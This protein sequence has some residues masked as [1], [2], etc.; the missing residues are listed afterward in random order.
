MNYLMRSMLSG[1]DRGRALMVRMIDNTES[2][3]EDAVRAGAI[4]PSRD[5]KARAGV[6]RHERRR[7]PA[8]LVHA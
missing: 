6:S 1:G 3:L 5:P 4:K 7:I 2:S 8:L